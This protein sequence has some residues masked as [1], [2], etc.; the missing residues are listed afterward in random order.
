MINPL[1][2]VRSTDFFKI[3]FPTNAVYSSARISEPQLR[4]AMR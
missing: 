4:V 2:P 3:H 1:Y